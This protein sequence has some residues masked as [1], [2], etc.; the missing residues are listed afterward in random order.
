MP[1]LLLVTAVG[2]LRGPALVVQRAA[3]AR[4]HIVVASADV[5]VVATEEPKLG[6][7]DWGDVRTLRH[8]VVLT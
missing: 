6:P 2:A 1:W 5:A 8:I 3:V 7:I 4:A